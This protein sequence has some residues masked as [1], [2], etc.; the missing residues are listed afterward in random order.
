MG[1]KAKEKNE[2][3]LETYAQIINRFTFEFN[4][5]FCEEGKINWQE[6][7]KFNSSS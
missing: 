2:E 7:V 1:Y 3:F 5:K 6:L 4:Q